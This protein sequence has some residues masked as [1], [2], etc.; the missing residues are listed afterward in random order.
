MFLISIK[1]REIE[2]WRMGR[3]KRERGFLRFRGFVV[4]EGPL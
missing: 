2:M 1:I 3:R 4:G